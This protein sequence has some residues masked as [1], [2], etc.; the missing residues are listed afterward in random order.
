MLQS[1]TKLS[2]LV[3]RVNMRWKFSRRSC[4][5][6]LCALFGVAAGVASPPPP[7]PPALGASAHLRLPPTQ[8]QTLAR[9]SERD[10]KR[11]NK[12][13]KEQSGN[14]VISS[15][16]PQSLHCKTHCVSDSPC[17]LPGLLSAFLSACLCV[18]QR[19]PAPAAR[20]KTEPP[21]AA[22]PGRGASPPH[23]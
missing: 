10:P 16:H 11:Q 21:G 20:R 6:L 8:T 15:D 17:R 2:Q 5:S 3:S 23:L 22:A 12:C 13:V 18:E 7:H 4:G 14:H 9:A 1:Q 19:S